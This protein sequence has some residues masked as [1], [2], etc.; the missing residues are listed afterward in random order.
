[1]SD[2]A[3]T[4]AADELILGVDGPKRG[5]RRRAVGTT[6]EAALEQIPRVGVL[7]AQVPI[8][9]LREIQAHIRD[10]ELNQAVWV[11]RAIVERYLR[12]G[13]DPDVAEAALD[14]RVDTRRRDVPRDQYGQDRS[15]EGRRRR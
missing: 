8:A 5:W 1:V 15:R 10:S 9:P 6:R 3:D 2:P 14:M 11:R 4:R 7:Q 13:G 12:E